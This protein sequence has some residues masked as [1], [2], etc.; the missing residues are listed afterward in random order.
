MS[1]IIHQQPD[2]KEALI[3]IVIGV[4]GHRDLRDEDV[5]GLRESVN[6]IFIEFRDLYPST[7][8]VVLTSL[9][10]GADRLVARAAKNKGASVIVSLPMPIDEYKKDFASRG[11]IEE[12][13]ELLNQAQDWFVVP[14]GPGATDDV[15]D[16]LERVESYTRASQYIASHCQVLIALWDGQ[17][18]VLRGGTAHTIKCKLEG[19]FERS[20]RTVDLLNWVDQG[21]VYQIVTPRISNPLPKDIP[22]IKN[23]YFPESWEGDSIASEFNYRVLSNID[24]FNENLLNLYPTIKDQIDTSKSYMVS[25]DKL[26]HL[27]PHL[28]FLRQVYA[29]ADIM[30]LWFQKRRNHTMI[31]LFVLGVCSLLFF[32]LYSHAFS[33]LPWVL[34]LYP[35]TLGI[36]YLLFARAKHNHYQDRHLDYRTLAE[37]LR[38][39]LFW[40]MAG[41]DESVSDYYLPRHQGE[42]VWL[43]YALKNCNLFTAHAEKFTYKPTPETLRFV[44]DNWV[45]DQADFFG[46]TYNRDNNRQNRQK[47]WTMGMFLGGLLLSVFI[48]LVSSLLPHNHFIE[49]IHSPLIIIIVLSAAI[50]AAFEGYAEKMAVS[51]QAKQ[52]HR[53]SGLFSDALEKLTSILGKNDL[54]GAQELV[55]ELGKE[56]LRENCDWLLMHR[57]RPMKVPITG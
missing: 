23:V 53:M 17:E 20:G 25:P 54:T 7:P 52:Y 45:K 29:A 50:A 22:F 56:A 48:I 1:D 33:D 37:G 11:S 51:E 38:V 18:N 14:P 44:V 16:V 42:L 36:A 12:F 41:I 46:R 26:H 13:N 21:P 24:S 27:P 34:A 39:Q 15:H 30:A 40:E 9:A 31:S 6:R 4:T 10:E 3:P 57:E 35:A 8:F 49:T 5:S 43:L 47:K 2:S 32:E 28:L 55:K 19:K